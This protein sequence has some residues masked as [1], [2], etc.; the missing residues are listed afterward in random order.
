[1]S[2][3]SSIPLSYADE[4]MRRTKLEDVMQPNSKIAQELFDNNQLRMMSLQS[5][6][7]FI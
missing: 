2:E 7:E 5:T 3:N 1:M 6:I 4:R